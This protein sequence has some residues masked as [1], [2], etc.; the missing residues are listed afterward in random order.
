MR[1]DRIA[2]V[3]R[4]RIVE[5]GSHGELVAARGRYAAMYAT[6]VSQ[7]DGSEHAPSGTATG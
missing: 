5:V 4:G 2:V 3:D 1:A 6:W 7:S